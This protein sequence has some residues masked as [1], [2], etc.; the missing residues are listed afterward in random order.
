M[1]VSVCVNGRG[2]VHEKV[3][4]CTCVCEMIKLTHQVTWNA[5]LQLDLW[6]DIQAP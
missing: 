4:M 6:Q 3:K 1:C 2:I 5:I